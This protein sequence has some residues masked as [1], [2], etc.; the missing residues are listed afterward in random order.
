MSVEKAAKAGA[1]SALDTVLR[2]GVAF[3][4]S[5][6][7]ARLL[8]PQ[9]FGLMA[10]LALFSSLSLALVQG[11]FTLALIQRQ[12]TTQEEESTV[13]WCNLVASFL[14]G[15][16][17]IAAAPAVADFYGYPVLRGL[18]FLIAGQVV[19]SS[20]GAVHMA[21]LT[22]NLRFDRL[23]RSGIVS[24]VVS[25]AAG[26]TAA[27]MG[28]GVWS[29]AVQIL[30][31]AIVNSAMLWIVSDWR[32]AF[33]V[34]L[35]AIADLYRFGLSISLSTVLEVVYTQGFAA[36]VGKLHGAHDLGLFNRASTTQ[37]LPGVIISEIISRVA[38]PLFSAR[39][40]EAEALKRGF[41][42]SLRL[43]TLITFPAAAGLAILSDLVLLCLFGEQ[44]VPA[45]KILTILAFAGCL[46]PF[47]VLNLQL[48]LAAGQSKQFLIIEIQKKT[49]GVAVVLVGSLFGV[50]GLAY[51]MV[52]GGVLSLLLNSAPAKRL[53]GH[54]LAAQI[55]DSKGAVAATAAMS[56]VVYSARGALTLSPWAELPLLVTLGAA[57][58]LAFGFGLRLASFTEALK[59]ARLLVKKR[60]SPQY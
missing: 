15:A 7:L 23:A 49:M 29:L 20:L 44:W 53:V 32:P 47:H 55:Y 46:M 5:I 18:M 60:Q 13:F 21:L 14:F 41:R 48:L 12:T 24:S 43:A 36:I 22:R 2:Q 6:V 39:N 52:V 25:G 56:L 17:I 11:G 59:T 10:L 8:A 28:W 4:V 58:Y 30:T 33:Q 1:W 34:R 16:I 54:G 19:A 27:I 35:R 57:S 26:I 50:V 45:A 37:A 51:A 9:D 38:L 40:S 3:A 31:M 42:M